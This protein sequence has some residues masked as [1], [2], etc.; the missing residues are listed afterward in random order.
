M[1]DFQVCKEGTAVGDV[2]CA[3]R[4]L[5]APPDPLPTVSAAGWTKGPD[6]RL[7]TGHYTPSTTSRHP[8]AYR[9]RYLLGGSV[10]TE[11]RRAHELQIL[12][13]HY[14]ALTSSPGGPSRDEYRWGEHIVGYQLGT[15]L[16]F[17]AIMSAAPG[18]HSQAV[19]IPD[20]EKRTPKPQHNR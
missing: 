9:C 17:V 19:A 3:P 18:L 16:S 12:E 2:A 13:A 11:V 14:D 10:D 20:A 8:E 6:P 7:P 1:V 15:L 5:P 4:P